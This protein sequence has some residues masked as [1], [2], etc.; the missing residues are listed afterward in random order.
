MTII[1]DLNLK[2]S[3]EY[4]GDTNMKAARST[5]PRQSVEQSQKR[6]TKSMDKVEYIANNKSFRVYERPFTQKELAFWEQDV[7]KRQAQKFVD[8][9]TH[10]SVVISKV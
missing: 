8:T 2:I 5:Y 4:R 7:Y 9:Q 3:I 1:Q 6:C 10:D